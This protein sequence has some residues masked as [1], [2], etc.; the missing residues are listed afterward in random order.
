MGN[1][2]SELRETRRMYVVLESQARRANLGSADVEAPNTA[3]KSMMT[4]TL[5]YCQTW[6]IKPGN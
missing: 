6:I 1:D 2:L 3:E 4:V 5:E